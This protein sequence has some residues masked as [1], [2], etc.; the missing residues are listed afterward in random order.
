MTMAEAITQ[1]LPAP[2]CEL[3]EGPH[4]DH[5]T[6][7]AWWFDILGCKLLEHRFAS[8]ITEIHDLPRMGSV[9]AKIDAGHQLL[10]M[11]D[12]LYLR[13]MAGGAVTLL[14][15][16]EADNPSTRSNDGRVHPS[17]RLWIGTMGRKAEKDAGAIYWFDGREVRRLFSGI[18]VPNSICFSSDGRTGHFADTEQRRVWRVELDPSTGLPVG[19]PEVFLTASDLPLGGGFDGSVTDRNGVLWNAAWNSGSVTGFAPDGSVVQT[20]EVPAAQS[21]CPA[22]VGENLD[23]M[24]I[25]TAR[26]GYTDEQRRAD[27]GAGFTYVI[28]GGFTGTEDVPFKLED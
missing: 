28:D 27:P 15:P 17:G 7:T 18:T 10:A 16:L 23:R 20:F 5:A 24:L 26:Q 3:G 21:T 8:G 11:D 12:G 9:V 22:F 19:E 4:Y 2:S 25:T 14:H 6:A 1:R 13:K